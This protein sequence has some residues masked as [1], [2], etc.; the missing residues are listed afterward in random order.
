MT[1]N[2]ELAQRAL[3]LLGNDTFCPSCGTSYSW[4]DEPASISFETDVNA[5]DYGEGGY[6]STPKAE[7]YLSCEATIANTASPFYGEKCRQRRYLDLDDTLDLATDLIN[8]A[9]QQAFRG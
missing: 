6:F 7:V 8:D 1:I 3:S 5:G 9:L 2:P 4:T